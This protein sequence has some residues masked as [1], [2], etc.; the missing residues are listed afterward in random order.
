MKSEYRHKLKFTCHEAGRRHARLNLRAKIGGSIR[1]GR[2]I[3][4]ATRQT[5]CDTRWYDVTRDVILRAKKW[6]LRA[7]RWTIRATRQTVRARRRDDVT[8][9]VIFTRHNGGS[10][11]ATRRTI[12]ATMRNS[13]ATRQT[14]CASR[15]DD[16]TR[17]VIFTRQNGGSLRAT[18]RTM[19]ATRRNSLATRQTVRG[20]LSAL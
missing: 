15:R 10:L 11:R 6:N 8:R 12:R 4:R 20:T 5:I 2:R 14:V 16:V 17:D 7:T 18:R 9:D 1:A 13:L 3:M 19:R